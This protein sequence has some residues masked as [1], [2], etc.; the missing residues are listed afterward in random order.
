VRR[1]DQAEEMRADGVRHVLS[2]DDPDFDA[3]LKA[4]VQTCAVAWPS[5]PWA[6]S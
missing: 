6:A 4:L 5:T 1:A 3:T 2:T